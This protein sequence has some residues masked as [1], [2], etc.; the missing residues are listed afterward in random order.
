VI[1]IHED[2]VATEDVAADAYT[3][4]PNPTSSTLTIRLPQLHLPSLVVYNSL[5]Q[6]MARISSASSDSF[7]VDAS[8]W[9]PGLYHYMI[10][11]DHRPV[12]YNTV[13]VAR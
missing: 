2:M 11:S 9:S 3:V 13:S 12:Y 1:I 8:A 5:G 7:T 10:M 6:E 4:Y